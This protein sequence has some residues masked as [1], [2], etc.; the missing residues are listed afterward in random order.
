M[1]TGASRSIP[2]GFDT[3]DCTGMV[4]SF[5]VPAA[6]D[7]ESLSRVYAPASGAVNW[8]GGRVAGRRSVAV[9]PGDA[10]AVERGIAELDLGRP[11]A[12]QEEAH[13]VLVGHPDAAVHLDA[14][15]ADQ[16]VGIGAARFGHARQPG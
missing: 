7:A 14:L 5:L 16:H 12:L 8:L 3:P 4:D 1:D 9:E 11:R 2:T 6:P 15:V 13:V 10:V